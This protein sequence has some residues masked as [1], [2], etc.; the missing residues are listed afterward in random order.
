MQTAN[1]ILITDDSE[2]YYSKLVYIDLDQFMISRFPELAVVIVDSLAAIYTEIICRYVYSPDVLF[3]N[4]SSYQ[5][6]LH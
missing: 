3:E 6:Y 2:S 5:Y 4:I 1:I